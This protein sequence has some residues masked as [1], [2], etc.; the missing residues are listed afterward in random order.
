MDDIQIYPIGILQSPVQLQSSVDVN[1]STFSPT[2]DSNIILNN[3]T[4]SP[5][6][7]TSIILLDL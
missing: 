6:S 4:T 2:S 1:E 3:S 7:S 5:S